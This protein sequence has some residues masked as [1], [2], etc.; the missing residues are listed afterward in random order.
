MQHRLA[1]HRMFT[2]FASWR[3]LA[4]YYLRFEIVGPFFLSHFFFYLC[5]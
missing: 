4:Y 1:I 5:L 3:D 2:W